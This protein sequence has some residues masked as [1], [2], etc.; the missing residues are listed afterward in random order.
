M[1][2]PYGGPGNRIGLMFNFDFT[3]GDYYEVEFAPTG[4]AYFNKF[5]QGQLTRVATATHSAL[6][7][8]TW[9]NVE[10]TRQ[11]PNATVKVNNQ[12]VF[13]NVPASQFDHSFPPGRTDSISRIGVTFALGA[14]TL[15]R[16][17]V[18]SFRSIA[19]D[20][21]T[22]VP[23]GIGHSFVG[24]FRTRNATRSS[25]SASV[26]SVLRNVGMKL[27]PRRTNTFTSSGVRSSRSTSAAGRVPW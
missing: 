4:E 14:R 20:P 6:G 13:A 27:T 23:I 15:R 16:S 8:N 9:F 5:M 3:G 17:A 10:W 7:R 24:C 1:L 26:S 18:R 25:S 22:D 19:D 21:A 11:G 2:N 12:I